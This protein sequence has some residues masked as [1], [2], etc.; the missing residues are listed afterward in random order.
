MKNP[1]MI[2]WPIP[3]QTQ[4]GLPNPNFIFRKERKRKP[5]KDP[6]KPKKPQTAFLLFLNKVCKMFMNVHEMFKSIFLESSVIQWRG[7]YKESRR[8][9]K[10]GLR[11][12]ESAIRRRQRAVYCKSF[13]PYNTRCRS[14]SI[15]QDRP[16]SLKFDSPGTCTGIVKK[17]ADL[18]A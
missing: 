2:M 5:E 14:G 15:D 9:W 18:C 7:W 17:R 3:T 8:N 1:S 12:M 16:V 13:D 6:N 10:T 11:K 4:V